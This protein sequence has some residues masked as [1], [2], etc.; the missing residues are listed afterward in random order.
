MSKGDIFSQSIEDMLELDKSL[1]INSMLDNIP[2]IETEKEEDEQLEEPKKEDPVKPSPS[3]KKP[4]GTEP[5]LDINK[6]LD[7]VGKEPEDETD[8]EIDEPEDTDPAANKQPVEKSSDAPFTVIFA[9]DLAKQGLISSFDEKEFN[10]KV[11]ELGE[12]NALRALI[13][14]EIEANIEAAKSDLDEGYKEYL[15]LIGKGVPA[16]TAGNLMELKTRFDSIKADD[17]TKEE[18]VDLRK[19]VMTD[20]FK[21]TTSMSD[22]KIE[23]LVQNSIDLGEDIDDSK[24]YLT[25]LKSA[26]KEQV[27]AEEAEADRQKAL[28]ADENK[29]LMNS[30]KETINTMDEVIPGL[31]INKQTRIKMYEALTKEVQDSKGRITNSLWAKRAEDP[32]FFDSRLAY[33]LE[34]GFFEKGKTWTKA[35]MAKTTKEITE[36][37][38]ALKNRNNTT[39]I[40]GS[41]VIKSLE[42]DKTVKSN[43]DSMRGIFGK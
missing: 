37:E 3:D 7:K 20:Y 5:K 12:A 36:L 19:K 39:S 32:I 35:G 27:E 14:D 30:L 33:L 6:I 43:I 1:D 16:D 31:G 8:D 41:P 22:A 21:L 17:L 42:E 11:A 4:K 28:R 23:K 38:A 13:K 40:S 2:A 34:T 15:N 26:I 25:T 9:K 24:E 18:N 10:E 29:R